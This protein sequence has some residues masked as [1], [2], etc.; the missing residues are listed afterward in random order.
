MIAIQIEQANFQ[1]FISREPVSVLLCIDSRDRTSCQLLKRLADVA[2]EFVSGISFAWI[3][4]ASIPE[5]V[6]T[7]ID[8]NVTPSLM[9]F[10]GGQIV[11]N[12]SE[13]GYHRVVKALCRSNIL[14]WFG[15]TDGGA[16]LVC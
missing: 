8:C 2:D 4:F 7:E 15:K 10:R 14:S 9:F 5:T 3:D 11:E 1:E 6:I 12:A 16:T 13:T